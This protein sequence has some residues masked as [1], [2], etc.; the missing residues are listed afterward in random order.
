MREPGEEDR[1]KG[2][3]HP[4]HATIKAH[5]IFLDRDHIAQMHEYVLFHCCLPVEKSFFKNIII[6]ALLEMQPYG[7]HVLCIYYA[8]SNLCGM[9]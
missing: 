2:S 5:W 8:F 6:V 1:R 9:F 4:P 3:P 7:R